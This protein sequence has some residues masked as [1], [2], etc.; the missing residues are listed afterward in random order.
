MASDRTPIPHPLPLRAWCEALAA[1]LPVQHIAPRGVP[2]LDRYFISGYS[3]YRFQRPAPQASLYL[4]HFLSSDPQDEVH[5]HP[6]GWAA[7][8][9]LV[10]GY[11]EYRCEGDAITARE[12]RPGAI[13][14][15]QPDTRHRV[16]LLEADGWSLVLVGPYAQPWAFF[17]ECA[18]G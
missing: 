14:V 15:L 1:T 6:W 13:N 10:G 2:Y 17:A 8:L 5:S 18:D 16:E 12:F 4:H 11:R 3:P 7:S 9:L